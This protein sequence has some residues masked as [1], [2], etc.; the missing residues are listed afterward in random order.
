[1]GV[2]EFKQLIKTYFKQ[3][4]NLIE[5]ADY[6]RSGGQTIVLG[7][8]TISFHDECRDYDVWYVIYKVE[9]KDG[10]IEYFQQLGTYSSWEGIDMDD[11]INKVREV[12]KTITVWEDV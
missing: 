12:Q 1:M 8:Y 2:T 10:T 6:M 9:Y 3:V 11:E 7:D 5:F 4:S